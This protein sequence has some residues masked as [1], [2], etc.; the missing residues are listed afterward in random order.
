MMAT[1]PPLE[2]PM[3]YL[4][5]SPLT[6]AISTM[7]RRSSTSISNFPMP[8]SPS[9]SPSPAKSNVIAVMGIDYARSE[10]NR[11]LRCHIVP[12]AIIAQSVV[13][14]SKIL[15]ARRSPRLFVIIFIK[16]SLKK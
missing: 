1:V 7:A 15:N 8:K 3:M 11:A 5:L 16:F 2:C 6:Y 9:L 13:S 10:M 14:L 12:C 4:T